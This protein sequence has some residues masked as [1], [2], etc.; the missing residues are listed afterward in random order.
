LLAD[1]EAR[2]RVVVQAVRPAISAYMNTQPRSP[3]CGR[4]RYPITSHIDMENARKKLL[5]LRT[6]NR[7]PEASPFTLFANRLSVSGTILRRGR[8][9]S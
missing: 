6:G 4:A 9:R 8:V 7:T 3:K 1:H 2:V 5:M